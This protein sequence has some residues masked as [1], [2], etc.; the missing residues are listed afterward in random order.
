MDAAEGL[1]F[2]VNRNPNPNRSAKFR[3]IHSTYYFAYTA[4][5]ILQMS[6]FHGFWTCQLNSLPPPLHDPSLLPCQDSAIN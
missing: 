5:F 2:M 6:Q 3:S 1:G 4:F